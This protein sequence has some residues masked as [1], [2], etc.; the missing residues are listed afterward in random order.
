MGDYFR[1]DISQEAILKQ[2]TGAR[3][4]NISLYATKDYQAFRLDQGRS[5][6]DLIRS[7]FMIDTDKILYNKFYNRYADK[8]Q[9]FSFIL[10]D[11]ITRRSLHVQLVSRIARTIGR[12]L[13]LNV[14]LIEAISLGHDIG[15]TPFGHKGEEFLDEKYFENTGRHFSHNVHSVRVL[16]ELTNCNLTLQTLDGILCHNGDKDFSHYEPSQIY[17]FSELSRR[18][19][20]CYLD[21]EAVTKMRPCTLEGC[22]VRISDMIAYV[23]RDRQDAISA[24]VKL[25]RDFYHEGI[26]GNNNREIIDRMVTN[27][28]KNSIGKTY[29]KIDDE[30]YKDFLKMRRE[31]ND[32][33]YRSPE[34]EEAYDGKVKT[35]LF[36]IYD[37]FMEDIKEDRRNSY[38]FRHHVNLDKLKDFYLDESSELKV[39]PDD[40]VVD[41][42]AS[43][44][45]DYFIDVYRRLFPESEIKIEYRKYFK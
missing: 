39:S 17:N 18:V 10:N 45:D 26:L 41:F 34:V 1:L 12:A 6:P 29:L 16:Q 36:S 30:V 14:D 42:I 22:V 40:L 4:K 7:S 24:K 19:E 2:E 27:I 43:M 13:N 23:G 25:D 9:V 15:H 35:M 37:K 32:I 11:D 44:T 5:K 28:V 8:T 20:A 33:I 38:V 31:N 21:S 3:N